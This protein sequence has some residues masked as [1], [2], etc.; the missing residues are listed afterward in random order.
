MVFVAVDPI[1]SPMGRWSKSCITNHDI[2]LPLIFFGSALVPHQQ[3]A[4]GRARVWAACG[5]D[6]RC[7]GRLGIYH[8]GQFATEN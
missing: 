1:S 2:H 3:T 8:G 5:R 7:E 4:H 6:A